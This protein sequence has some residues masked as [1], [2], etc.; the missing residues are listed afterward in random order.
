MYMGMAQILEFG[1]KKLC[2]E[3]FGGNLDEMERWTLG[4]TRVELE[5][6]G[7]RTDF[8]NLLMGVVDSRNHIAHEILANEAIM[9]GMLRKLNVNVA[10]YK[11]QRILWK[12]IIELEQICFLFD[13]T[14]EH[15]GWD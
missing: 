12:A 4:K 3:K 6:K 13:W 14:N 7:L 11:Y 9:N 1:L 5:K 10:F 2:E 15:N 8:V